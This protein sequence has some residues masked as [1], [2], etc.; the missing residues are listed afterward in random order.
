MTDTLMAKQAWDAL[1]RHVLAPLIPRCIDEECG[2]FLV[3]SDDQWRP[4]GPRDKSLEHAA[5]T[6]IAFAQVD[7]A[8]PGPGYER[9]VRHGCAFLQQAMWT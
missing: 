3:D 4:I 6:T 7:R 1:R 9:Y 5:R 8:M 2:G